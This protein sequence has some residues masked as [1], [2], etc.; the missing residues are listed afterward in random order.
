VHPLSPS[1]SLPHGPEL[2]V[3]FFPPAPTLSLSRRP[4]LS[5]VSNLPTT[6]SPPWTCPRP[7]VLRP[8]PRPRAPF[9]PH[10]LPAHLSSLICTLCPT[11]SPFLSLYPHV[12]RA[13]PPP[14]FD[15]CLFHGRRHARAPSSATVSSALLSAAR[16]T[17][18]CALSLPTALGPCTREQFLRSQSS[19]AVDPRFHRTFAVL[20]ALQSSHSR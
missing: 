10:A 16:D 13:P 7:R 18:R 5:T 12:Q 15:R 19:A 20:H 6:I 9:E 14:A 2:S 17:V 3:P 4:H 8:S 11:L 1:L